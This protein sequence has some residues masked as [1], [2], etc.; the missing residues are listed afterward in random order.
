LVETCDKQFD[1]NH[2]PKER[3]MKRFIQKLFKLESKKTIRA[4][5]NNSFQPR[6]EILEERLCLSSAGPDIHSDQLHHGANTKHSGSVTLS[7]TRGVSLQAI[8][9][10]AGSESPAV[11]D[12]FHK[13]D[14]IRAA[15]GP[16]ALAKTLA[17]ARKETIVTVFGGDA[18]KAHLLKQTPDE[19]LQFAARSQEISNR[20]MIFDNLTIARLANAGIEATLREEVKEKFSIGDSQTKGLDMKQVLEGIKMS[21]LSGAA[22]N[23]KSFWANYRDW[24]N[25]KLSDDAFRYFLTDGSSG[26]NPGQLTGGNPTG[27]NGGGS[28]TGQHD[29][30]NPS[31]NSGAGSNPGNPFGLPGGDTGPGRAGGGAGQD[32]SSGPTGKPG[33][34]TQTSG[35]QNSGGHDSGG[36]DSGG[37][38]NEG[39]GGGG[40][41]KVD[42]EEDDTCIQGRVREVDGIPM[43]DICYDCGGKLSDPR[44]DDA[45]VPGQWMANPQLAALVFKHD[46]SAVAGKHGGNVSDPDPN[47]ADDGSFVF[48]VVN[49]AGAHQQL[50][51]L[52]GAVA[53]GTGGNVDAERDGH[54][55]P[56]ITTDQTNLILIKKGGAVSNPER[57]GDPHTSSG[58]QPGGFGAR[59]VVAG[60]VPKA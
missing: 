45:V 54:D 11:Y 1:A 49:A 47:G 15:G 42:P 5:R 29:G 36:H 19:L 2:Q 43:V 16:D 52:N 23:D 51:L 50:Q 17:E 3:A 37:Q 34:A 8:Q 33:S 46:G 27:D 18:S 14:A 9:I 48:V 7:M 55:V 21:E 39:S 20:T 56:P 4:A 38:N 26:P 32:S 13:A 10:L 12:L 28:N 25:G 35:G 44:A 6:F 53:K 41:D 40:T 57:N 59:P 58:P 30:G 24:T 22:A 60:P 31:G